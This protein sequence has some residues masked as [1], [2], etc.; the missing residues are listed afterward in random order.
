MDAWRPKHVEDQD[1]IKWFVYVFQCEL[2]SVVQHLKQSVILLTMK[3]HR[4]CD[5]A[6]TLSDHTYVHIIIILPLFVQFKKLC[7]QMFVT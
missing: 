2:K 6:V 1:T 7:T 4:A 5:K 3:I